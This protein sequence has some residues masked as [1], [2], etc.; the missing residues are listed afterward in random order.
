MLSACDSR[1]REKKTFSHGASH[2]GG[3]TIQ[4]QYSL[5]S[6]IGTLFFSLAWY[7]QSL[8]NPVNSVP[9]YSL[10]TGSNSLLG[11]LAK[12]IKNTATQAATATFN[13][14]RVTGTVTSPDR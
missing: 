2:H 9:A 4:I 5:T 13:C 3:A 11:E 8:C 1:T 7:N 10:R 6:C 12:S 14:Y